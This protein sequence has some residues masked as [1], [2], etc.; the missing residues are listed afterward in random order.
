M[1]ADMIV[2][3]VGSSQ[4]R[5]IPF[6][7]VAYIDGSRAPTDPEARPALRLIPTINDRCVVCA[8]TAVTVPSRTLGVLADAR[9]D[10]H[11]FPINAQLIAE[12]I[13]MGVSGQI[14]GA[15]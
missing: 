5:N 13:R 14:I 1:D 2:S 12:K 9:I 4:D 15:N 11:S 3:G 6:L 8:R 7:P 10:H